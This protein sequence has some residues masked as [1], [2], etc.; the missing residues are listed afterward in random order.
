MKKA[1]D[2]K[3]LKIVEMLLEDSRTPFTRIA[4]ELDVTEAA[5]RK[6]IK[7]L[8]EM[9]VILKY[10]IEV[11]SG[12]L[13]Y[14]IVSL[15]G[16]DAEADKVIEIAEK[17]KDFDFTKRV[18]ITAGDHMIMAEIWA[19]DKDELVKILSEEI[20]ALEGVKGVYPAIVL[21]KVK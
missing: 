9:G 2:R 12:K 21:E 18:F 6:R 8:E 16:I 3:D 4:K 10:T 15:T 17:L 5:I 11:D 14:S 7:T 1:L 13:G 19:K 20:G